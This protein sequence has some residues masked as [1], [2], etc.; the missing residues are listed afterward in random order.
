MQAVPNDSYCWHLSMKHYV[1]YYLS[2]ASFLRWRRNI[3]FMIKAK[4]ILTPS[5]P[6][7]II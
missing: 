5:N 4:V 3:Y 7:S 1:A 2:V 6:H